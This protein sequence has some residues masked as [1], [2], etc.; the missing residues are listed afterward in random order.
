MY[1]MRK[2]AWNLNYGDF[3][4]SNWSFFISYRNDIADGFDNANQSCLSPCPLSAATTGY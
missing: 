1:R 3:T 4:L 2:D